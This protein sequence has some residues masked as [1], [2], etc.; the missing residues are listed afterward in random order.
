MNE[1]KLTKPTLR[2]SF[3]DLLIS[4]KTFGAKISPHFGFIYFALMLAGITAV[5]YITTQTM[6]STDVGQGTEA[7]QKMSEYTITFDQSTITKLKTLSGENNS[8]TITLPSGR[9]NPFS[10][11]IY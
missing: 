8:P 11:S 3:N 5:V 7:N 6:Q 4:L 2:Q 1:A 9:I 10:E